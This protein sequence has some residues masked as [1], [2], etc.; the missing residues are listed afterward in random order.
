MALTETKLKT[1]PEKGESVMRNMYRGITA[2]FVALTIAGCAEGPRAAPAKGIPVASAKHPVVKLANVV[3]IHARVA[4][5]TSKYNLH[6]PVELSRVVTLRSAGTSSVDYE[7]IIAL[8]GFGTAF[9][10]HPQKYRLAYRYPQMTKIVEKRITQATGFAR[11]PVSGANTPEGAWNAL[12]KAIDAKT[13]VAAAF[14]EG[15]IFAGYQDAD[16]KKDRKIFVVGAGEKPLWW[17]WRQFTD[18]RVGKAGRGT[19]VR[20]VKKGLPVPPKDSA[21]E[22]MKSIVECAKNDARAKAKDAAGA[23]FGF[24]GIR[25]YDLDVSD[26]KKKP[27]FFHDAWRGG[28]AIYRQAAGR[29]CM[30]V[31]L[32]RVAKEFPEKSAS[33]ILAAAGEY[34]AA[35][36]E[37]GEW[38]KYLSKNT[39]NKA[40]ETK[41][42]RLA[43]A[44]AITR[45]RK[46]E[47][48]AASEIYKGLAAAGIKMAQSVKPP[49][50]RK[51]KPVR[52]PPKIAPLTDKQKQAVK[53]AEKILSAARDEKDVGKK[54]ALL[55]NA[56]VTFHQKAKQHKQAVKTLDIIVNLNGVSEKNH[57]DAMFMKGQVAIASQD[58]ANG[59]KYYGEF[60]GK[61]PHDPRSGKARIQMAYGYMALRKRGEAIRVL[62]EIPDNNPKDK[63]AAHALFLIGYT[64]KADK[65]HKEAYKAFQRILDEYPRSNYAV[66]A[67]RFARQYEKKYK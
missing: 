58:Q 66:E 61:Y 57:A 28:G 10:Y 62:Q 55:F 36:A 38:E 53:E 21:I 31:Y 43:G 39:P 1:P 50:A 48:L 19:F 2:L 9:A 25:A 49:V 17:T 6:H 65:N 52:R 15:L 46:H 63:L 67:N 35:W 7:T 34:E 47:Q 8:S 12:K 4:Q 54:T 64:H 27:E 16:G 44:A 26:Y 30:A 56:A 11:E 37:W 51:L 20:I 3:K 24:V 59:V 22:V 23:K 13:P 42:N 5:E 45:A 29:K 60:V 33:H 41:L 40:W 14:G 32:R 18:W